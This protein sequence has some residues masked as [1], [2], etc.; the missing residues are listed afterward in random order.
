MLTRE[1]YDALLTECFAREPWEEEFRQF[2]QAYLDGLFEL[3]ASKAPINGSWGN[4]EFAA[5]VGTAGEAPAPGH[6]YLWVNTESGQTERRDGTGALVATV[7][8]L[9]RARRHDHASYIALRPNGAGSWAT[10]V[11]GEAG[12]LKLVLPYVSHTQADYTTRTGGLSQDGGTTYNVDFD[13]TSGF[14]VCALGALVVDAAGIVLAGRSGYSNDLAYWAEVLDAPQ[15]VKRLSGI[16]A[17]AAMLAV[18]ASSSP[19]TI[20][21]AT[22]PERVTLYAGRASGTTDTKWVYA[23][24]ETTAGSGSLVASLSLDA[25]ALPAILLTAILKAGESIKVGASAAS[26]FW[27]WGFAQEMEA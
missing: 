27:A 7:A 12:K 23:M 14:G 24:G 6:D 10:L 26:N 4:G 25:K 8:H 16:P 3:A 11:T 2:H 20:H 5:G 17:G 21:T 19:A 18:P 9:P 13:I 22:K 1:E 15:G